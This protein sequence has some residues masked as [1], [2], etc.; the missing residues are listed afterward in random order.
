MEEFKT[1]PITLVTGYLGSGKTTLLNHIL[2]NTKGYKCAVIVNDIGEVNIDAELIEKGGIV[3][4][5]DENLV[6]LQNGCICCTLRQ[7]L[8]EQIHEIIKQRRFDHI[9]IEASGICEP[10]PIAQTINFL[11][12]S[13]KAEGLP[14]YC[15]LDAVVSVVDAL[16]MAQEFGCGDDL[17]KQNI[18]EEDIENLV[19]QQIE[20]CD[21]LILNKVKE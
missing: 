10:I 14:V 4:K 17:V 16:R 7:D 18:G 21:V 9:I 8:I 13:F 1:V 11:T 3:G 15:K 6:A 2:T 12:E 19:I 20:F 5:K